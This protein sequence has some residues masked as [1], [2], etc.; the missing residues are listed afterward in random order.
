MYL[1]EKLVNYKTV[2]KITPKYST[3]IKNIKDIR[4]V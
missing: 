3:D 2:V 1:I 4:T